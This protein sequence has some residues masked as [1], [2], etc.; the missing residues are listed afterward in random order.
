MLLKKGTK[1]QRRKPKL[2]GPAPKRTV[3]V[4]NPGRR[5]RKNRLRNPPSRVGD[6]GG[7]G[8][9][10]RTETTLEEGLDR[11]PGH[12]SSSSPLFGNTSSTRSEPDPTPPTTTLESPSQP[13]VPSE[14]VPSHWYNE[15]C[16]YVILGRTWRIRM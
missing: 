12:R 11:R 5:T 4:Q 2:L 6:V 10:D 8:D 7:G 3:S 15:G 9:G 16:R 13:L 14:T 1:R